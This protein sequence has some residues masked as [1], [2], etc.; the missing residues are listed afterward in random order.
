MSGYFLLCSY[1]EQGVRNI[2][3][4]PS[5]R[6]AAREL[7]KKLGVEIKAAYMAMGVHDL[8]LHAEAASD[9]AVAKFVLSLASR[10][11]LRTTTVKVFDEAEVDK[12]IAA[13]V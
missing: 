5:R 9:E 1:T 12:I 11:N 6:A 13:V 3:E 4:V 8:I 2:K 7:G 10:G